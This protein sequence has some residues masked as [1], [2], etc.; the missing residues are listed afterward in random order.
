MRGRLGWSGPFHPGIRW[1]YAVLVA[2]SDRRAFVKVQNFATDPIETRS[3]GE[4]GSLMSGPKE[5]I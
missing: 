1:I 5:T 3:F 4:W 2:S